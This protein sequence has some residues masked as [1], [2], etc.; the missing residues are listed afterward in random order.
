MEL[1]TTTSRTRLRAAIEA[2][3]EH[4]RAKVLRDLLPRERLADFMRR[5]SP[6]IPPPHHVERICE[7]VER[8][9]ARQTF[10]CFS[11]PPRHS[12]TTTL[13]HAMTWWLGNDPADTCAYFSYSDRQ[14]RSKS[15]VARRLAQIAGVEVDPNTNDMS[16][17]RTLS[18]GGVLAGGAG[19]GLTGQGVS[20]LF[21]VDD[22]VKNREQADSLVY[23]DRVWEW[24]REVVLT[25]LEGAS[26]VV[27]HT[28]WHPDDLIGRIATSEEFAD[29]DIVNI[30]AIAEEN[31][32]LHRD[33][34][35][36]LWPEKF[37]LEF[38]QDMQTKLGDWSFGA[39]YQGRPRPRGTAVFGDAHYYEPE[40]L[41]ITGC[42]IAIGADPA[43][44]A[45]TRADYSVAVVMAAHG[46]GASAVGRVLD[47]WRGQVEVPTFVD[48][49]VA[50][51]RR[52]GNCPIAVE[53]VGGFKAIPQML[54]RI[55]PQLILRSVKMGADKF[56]R[57]QP[58]AAAWNSGRLLLPMRAAWLRDLTSEVS[59]FTGTGDAHDD[60]VDALAHAWNAIDSDVELVAPIMD[61]TQVPWQR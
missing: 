27:M 23:R 13:L 15:R 52:Y 57:A 4:L 46:Y 9:R 41:D 44:T 54:K 42:R 28:R 19:G 18:G 2:M 5:I 45:S 55:D 25:R 8:A 43:A 40:Q 37:P 48:A 12:K 31:D 50:L 51:S 26:V 21:I 6:H 16:E 10:T 32:P 17:W 14:G 24:F 11:M 56:T 61:M 3:P 60:I 58:V 1:H 22:P 34:G 39:L 29:W 36:P 47:V 38:L 35:E 49:L 30:P 53:D 33:P 20:G 59:S 7:I